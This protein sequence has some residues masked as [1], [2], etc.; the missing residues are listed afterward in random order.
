MK[1]YPGLSIVTLCLLLGSGAFADSDVEFDSLKSQDYESFGEPPLVKDVGPA[2][3]PD[4]PII[5]SG[6]CSDFIDLSA[7]PLPIEVAGTT[8]GASNDYGPFTERPFCWGGN[9]DEQSG[10]GPD[11]AFRWTYSAIVFIRIR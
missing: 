3:D 6:D 8:V 9:W 5:A 2:I 10:A 11:I 7:L 1:R 4:A